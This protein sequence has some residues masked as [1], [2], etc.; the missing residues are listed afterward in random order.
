M[1]ATIE[2]TDLADGVNLRD[3]PNGWVDTRSWIIKDVTGATGSERKFNAIQATGVFRGTFH[4]FLPLVVC[5]SRNAKPIHNSGTQWKVTC[6]YSLIDE[7]DVPG[8]P[9]INDIQPATLSIRSGIQRVTTQKKLVEDAG[10]FLVSDA[11]GDLAREQIVL[12]HT[13]RVEKGAKGLDRLHIG[14]AYRGG[15][16]LDI[17]SFPEGSPVNAATHFDIVC[18]QAGEVDD[19][20]IVTILTYSRW[21]KTNPAPKIPD[22]VNK[23]NKAAMSMTGLAVKA[24]HVLCSRLDSTF[25]P[26]IPAYRVEYEFIHN[27]DSGF[28]QDVIYIDTTTGKPP[29]GVTTEPTPPG[30]PA[31]PPDPPILYGLRRIKLKGETNFAVLNLNA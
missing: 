27:K 18:Q 5:K 6:E 24:R 28:D 19:D 4:P 26:T 13:F 29:K 17:V 22:F 23:V 16:V 10:G 15:E 30:Q 12:G 21:E 7:T 25:N 31:T 11:D 2:T 9:P 8:E 3:T 14:D 20:Q 1:A